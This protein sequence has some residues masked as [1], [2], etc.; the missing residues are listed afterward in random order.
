MVERSLNEVISK[1]K[2]SKE[3][4]IVG[5]GGAGKEL[6]QY[7]KLLQINV[8]EF[9]DNADKF[10]ERTYDGIKISKP[11][12]R[13]DEA[14]LYVVTVTDMSVRKSLKEQLI[15]LNIPEQ[16]IVIYHMY[17]DYDF[18]SNL[19]TQ[20][21]AEEHKQ[22]AKDV[23][24][25]DLDV[26]NP[27]TYNEKVFVDKFYDITEQKVRL[28]DKY[29]VRDWVKEKI[30]EKYLVKQY[31]VWNDA[32]EIDFDMLPSSFVLKANHGSGYNIV[33]KDKSKIDKEAV[34]KQLN[35]WLKEKYG[36][37]YFELHYNRIEPKIVCE[38]YLEGLA[39]NVYDYNIYCFHGEPKYIHCIK[40][41]KKADARGSYY[42]EQWNKQPF[43]HG[44]PIDEEIAPKPKQL[45]EMLKL[46]RILCKDFKHVRVDWYNM[47]DGRVLF[48][49]VTITPWGGIVKF[50]PEEY[51]QILGRLI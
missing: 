41:C 15:N 22:Q 30:G 4:V 37:N 44:Y 36:F 16:K 5:I 18:W 34:R 28:A 6:Y 47:P 43:S 7:L 1:A 14:C 25:Y 10:A 13:E 51:D 39:D 26:K 31:A 35:K 12:K 48:G 9:F 23:F 2:D 42:D 49:E 46:S 32:A 3:V 33:V 21:Y 45:D 40:G 11:Y 20:Y 8:T 29:L 27:K 17:R 19:E 38:E 50:I 24:G